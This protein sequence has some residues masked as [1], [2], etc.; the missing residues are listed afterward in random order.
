MELIAVQSRA[1]R[2]YGYRGGV[3]TVVFHSGKIYRYG[4]VP[5]VVFTAWQA[6]PSKGQYFAT[7]IRPRYHGRLVA[8]A[9]PRT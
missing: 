4:W 1:I 7:V 8:E 3:L 6:A 5:R 9:I 2:A